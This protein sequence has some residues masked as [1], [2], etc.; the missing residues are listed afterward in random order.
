M[1]LYGKHDQ[2]EFNA[3]R[4]GGAVLSACPAVPALVRISHLNLIVFHVEY[5]QRAMLI[6]NATGIAL[7]SIYHRRHD[8]PPY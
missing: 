5:I 2:R 4:T 1:V 8:L 3:H 7:V 6:A